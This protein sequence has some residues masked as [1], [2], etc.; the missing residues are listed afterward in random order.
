MAIALQE[1]EMEQKVNIAALFI[2]FIL[3]FISINLCIIL[4]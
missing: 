4:F 1:L 2:G 3:L